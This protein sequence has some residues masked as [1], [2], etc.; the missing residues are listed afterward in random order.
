MVGGVAGL[1]IKILCNQIDIRTEK[2]IKMLVITVCYTFLD[3]YL[4]G[5]YLN[6]LSYDVIVW[7]VWQSNANLINWVTS[8]ILYVKIFALF[9]SIRVLIVGIEKF[10]QMKEE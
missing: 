9:W 7:Y 5:L 4:W 6:F 2:K 1:E 10:S 3:S 8:I